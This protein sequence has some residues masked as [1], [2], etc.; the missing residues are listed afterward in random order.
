MMVSFWEL[1]FLEATQIEV[2]AGRGIGGRK[3]G[4]GD[5]RQRE[6]KVVARGGG[7]GMGS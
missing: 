5:G 1:S 4:L 6:A 3:G 7:W 2:R